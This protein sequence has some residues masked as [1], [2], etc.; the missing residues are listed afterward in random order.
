MCIL[1]YRHLPLPEVWEPDMELCPLCGE[2]NGFHVHGCPLE[3]E[4][5]P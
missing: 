5:E 1:P 3:G 4:Y 2:F